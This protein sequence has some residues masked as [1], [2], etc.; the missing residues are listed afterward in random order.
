MCIAILTL[1][2][3]ALFSC[4]KISP[5]SDDIPWN[6]PKFSPAEKIKCSNRNYN[7]YHLKRQWQK[8]SPNYVNSVNYDI[9]GL[10]HEVRILWILLLKKETRK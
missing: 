7:V 2:Q 1:Y 9:R 4:V 3:Q 6:F 8:C 10:L 5:S